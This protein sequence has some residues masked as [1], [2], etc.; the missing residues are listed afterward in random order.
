[1]ESEDSSSEKEK[2][3]QSS[4]DEEKFSSPHS[5]GGG[6]IPSNEKSREKVVIAAT[7]PHLN[8]RVMRIHLNQMMKEKQVHHSL[9]DQQENDDPLLNTEVCMV[10]NQP[11]KLKKT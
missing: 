3:E 6:S 11:L 1:M 8:Q 10:I 9:E 7:K 2:L 5:R 4:S